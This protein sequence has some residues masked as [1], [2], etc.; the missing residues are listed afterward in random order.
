MPL[1]PANSVSANRD[2][3]AISK[4]AEF[5]VAVWFMEAGWEVFIP[6]YQNRQTDFVVRV[7]GD[8]EL[9][10]IEVKSTQFDTLNAG[11]LAN[12]WGKQ[13]APFHYL[14]FIEG[15]RERGVILPREYFRNRGKTRYLFDLIA[16]YSTGEVRKSLRAFAFDLRSLNDWERAKRFSATFLA[17]HR[18]RPALPPTDD[19]IK[20]A[21]R[22]KRA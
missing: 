18:N 20:A 8:D 15:K 22:A 5:R 7:P 11:Q 13:T 3:A 12:E 10:A 21:R 4:A 2:T 14:V 1:V 6:A 16:G 9:L 19:E 17:L